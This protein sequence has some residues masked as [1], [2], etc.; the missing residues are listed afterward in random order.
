MP[1]AGSAAPRPRRTQQQRRAEAERR[2]LDAALRLVATQGSRKLS[3][4]AVGEES[5]Y[6][7]G[8]VNHHFGTREALIAALPEAAAA[9]FSMPDAGLT[10]FERLVARC[11]WYIDGL[12]NFAPA[13]QA[14]L[15]MWAEAAGADPTL[16]PIFEKRDH[17]FRGQVAADVQQGIE[18]GTIRADADPDTVAVLVVGQLRGVGLQLMVTPQAATTDSIKRHVELMLSGLR[19]S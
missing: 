12:S 19:S 7:R 17:T 6:S 2:V 8:I 1:K 10:G 16:R 13:G 14:A 15:L 5:G 9:R 18:E 4:A 3:I 11:L